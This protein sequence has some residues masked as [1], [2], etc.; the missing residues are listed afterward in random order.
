MPGP[1][2]LYKE[3]AEECGRAVQDGGEVRQAW[4]ALMQWRWRGTRLDAPTPVRRPTA[5]HPAAPATAPATA[6]PQRRSEGSP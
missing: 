2:E 3:A 6:Q 5:P 1:V 4:S